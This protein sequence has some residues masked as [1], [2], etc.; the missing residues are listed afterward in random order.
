MDIYQQLNDLGLKQKPAAAYL[1][2]LKLGTASAHH[3]AKEANI[4]RT[5]IY[6]VLE[7]LVEKQLATKVIKGA[8]LSYTVESP[9]RFKQLILKQSGILESLLPILSAM[10]K[11]E[12]NKPTV[13]YYEHR[14]GICKAMMESLNGT[15]KLRR[16]FASVQE[17]VKLVGEQFLNRYI[18]ARVKHGISLR[19]LRCL[20]EREAVMPHWYAKDTNTDVLREVRYIEP[21]V[22]IEPMIS[23]YDH[24]VLMISAHNDPFALVIESADLARAMKVLFDIAWLT[25]KPSNIILTK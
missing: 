15:E 6:N 25:A 12:T 20:P 17:V 9:E 7:E 14:E 11:T 24:T 1:A 18:A 3:I 13:R 22:Q 10:R 4:E 8:R 5:T 16:D 21:G 19:S 23:V 2:L